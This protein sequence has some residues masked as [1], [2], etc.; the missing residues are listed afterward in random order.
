MLQVREN[1]WHVAV[2]A[3]CTSSLEPCRHPHQSAKHLCKGRREFHATL[4]PRR[5]VCDRVQR[6][7]VAADAQHS[8]I[9]AH[10]HLR[11]PGARWSPATTSSSR[12]I[13]WFCYTEQ[14]IC[15]CHA[16]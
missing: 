3:A 13:F 4:P 15:D 12:V 11:P 8:A 9:A 1:L 7:T 5:S 14:L 2:L 6:G 16:K 10:E